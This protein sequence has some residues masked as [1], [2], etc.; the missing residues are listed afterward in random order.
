MK[1]LPKRFCKLPQGWRRIAL[2]KGR[3]REANS[4]ISDELE[5]GLGDRESIVRHLAFTIGLSLYRRDG[6]AWDKERI[7]T[8]MNEELRRGIADEQSVQETGD[9]SVWAWRFEEGAA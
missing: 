2:P 7:L 1:E 6:G 5:M 8:V 3:W 9:D 4:T